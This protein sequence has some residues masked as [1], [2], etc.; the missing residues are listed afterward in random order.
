MGAREPGPVGAGTLA[1]SLLRADA[2][3]PPGA[4]SCHIPA[5][6]QPQASRSR[7]LVRG[8]AGGG[9]GPAKPDRGS[10]VRRGRGCS[11][12]SGARA[13]EGVVPRRPTLMRQSCMHVHAGALIPPHARASAH[14]RGGGPPVLHPATGG[15]G[16]SGRLP[17]A[18][19][20]TARARSVVVALGS[21]NRRGRE[22]GA[23]HAPE[24]PVAW[25]HQRAGA[26]AHVPTAAGPLA[27]RAL[28]E[29]CGLGRGPAGARGS[30]GV[31]FI[32][33]PVGHATIREK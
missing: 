14:A 19:A 26:Q 12:R 3:C 24:D 27:P 21:A 5:W 1:V 23:L 15:T 6:R 7:H 8:L 16:G 28:E 18:R 20:Q 13:S 9:R 30:V 25:G 4:A 32:G 11:E 33:W 22:W 10:G 29:P 2:D 17:P 31:P